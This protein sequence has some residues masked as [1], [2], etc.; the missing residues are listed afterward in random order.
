MLN[1]LAGKHIVGVTADHVW[2]AQ[3]AQASASMS[4]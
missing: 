1:V 3:A 2:L 4:P